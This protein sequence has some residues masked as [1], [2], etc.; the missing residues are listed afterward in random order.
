MLSRNQLN[1]PAP[2]L[3]GAAGIRLKGYGTNSV[4]GTAPYTLTQPG[5]MRRLLGVA[6]Y[7]VLAATN[8]D[9][10]FCTLVVN[11]DQVF[12]QIPGSSINPASNPNGNTVYFP[13]NRLLTGN[14]NIQFT[15]AATASAAY[16]LVVWYLPM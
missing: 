3:A 9:N 14:D 5:N 12:E 11:A 6:L 2:R 8:F 10:V 7:P 4:N 15:I 1:R 13:I 16:Q